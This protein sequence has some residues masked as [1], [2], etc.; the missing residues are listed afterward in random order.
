MSIV[1]GT[2]GAIMQGNSANKATNAQ[3]D[4]AENSIALQEKMY[5]TARSDYQPYM[6]AGQNALYALQGY[7]PQTTTTKQKV[8]GTGRYVSDMVPVGGGWER[9]G[10]GDQTQDTWTD[11][12][13]TEVQRWIPEEYKDV[14]NTTYAPTGTPM[15]PTGGAGKYIQQREDYNKNYTGYDPGQYVSKIENYGKNFTFDANDP[16]YKY[17]QQELEKSINRALASRGLY[18]SR[19]GINQLA[20]SNQALIG[21]EVD[22]QYTRGYNALKD[23]YGVAAGEDERKYTRGLSGITDAYNMALNTGKTQYGATYDIARLGAG[24]AAGGATSALQSGQS[25]SGSY[26]ALGN[27]IASGQNANSTITQNY[28]NGIQSTPMNA[29]AGY[30]MGSKLWNGMGSTGASASGANF[31]NSN[32]AYSLGQGDSALFTYG[33]YAA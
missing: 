14:T 27:A 1:S 25:I 21:Q 28:L 22:K 19:A 33:Q 30:N 2:I 5:D 16:A 26:N 6:Q 11:P 31:L 24:A 8:E 3:K 4:A 7:Q 12:A 15:D 10:K 29:L 9:T 13:N 20:D 18:D 23:T 32:A 17:Q